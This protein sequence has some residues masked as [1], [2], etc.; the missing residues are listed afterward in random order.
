MSV[1]N[2]LDNFFERFLEKYRETPEGLPMSPRRE[3]IDQEIYVGDSDADG[4]CRWKPIPYGR[5]ED[6]LRLLEVYG[7]QK[8]E[9]I[10][11]Y[12]CSYYCLGFDVMYKNYLIATRDVEVLDGYKRLKRV[13]D[14][15]TDQKGRITHISIGMEQHS[16]RTVVVEIKTGIVKTVNCDTGKMRKIAP[17]LEEFI[18]GWETVV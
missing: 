11:E 18:K 13:I 7:I 6:F 16:E 9:D 14:A 15:Y 1:K 17:S 10:V 3:D 5:K 4:Y 12:F 2:E 8:N